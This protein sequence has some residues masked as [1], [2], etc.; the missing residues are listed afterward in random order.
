[1]FEVA[2]PV[3]RSSSAS[4]LV[5]LRF[6]M[7]WNWDKI[8]TGGRL[9]QLCLHFQK[10]HE[11]GIFE[12]KRIICLFGSFVSW[13]HKIISFDRIRYFSALKTVAEFSF[14][15]L[16]SWSAEWRAPVHFSYLKH[17]KCFLS[18]L[19]ILSQQMYYF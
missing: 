2:H 10:Q 12:V 6:L 13:W 16:K 3:R 4:A 1:M 7:F 11:D 18:H 5:T 9:S 17:C 19:G 8:V 14:K 15:S